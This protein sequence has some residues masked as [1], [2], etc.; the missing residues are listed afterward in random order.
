MYGVFGGL[1]GDLGSGGRRDILFGA[2]D[3]IVDEEL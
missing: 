3:I 1:F 2:K